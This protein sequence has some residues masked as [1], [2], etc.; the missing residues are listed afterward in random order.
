MPKRFPVSL[1]SA[2][3]RR[4]IF[5]LI[6]RD[7]KIDNGTDDDGV[8]APGNDENNNRNNN[9]NINNN[10]SSSSKRNKKTDKCRPRFDL[11]KLV[12]LSAGLSGSEIKEACRDAAMV[13]VRECIKKKRAAGKL[14]H[15]VSADEVRG[16]RTTDFFAGVGAGTA[17]STLVTTAPTSLSKSSKPLAIESGDDAPVSSKESARRLRLRLRQERHRS[18]KQKEIQNQTQDR[19]KQHSRKRI[20]EEEVEDDDNN[21]N[22]SASFSSS[23]DEYE[24]E[25]DGNENENENGN[26]NN[27]GD[28]DDD[29]KDSIE[30]EFGVPAE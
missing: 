22:N 11:D 2:H 3:Q 6:L 19:S 13:P 1:P 5:K 20:K 21:N 30:E 24:T 4:G 15:G 9:N 12:R 7:T 28:D 14:M 17:A 26:V 23:S 8:D 16:L 18:R 10:S 29:D 25:E 27:N